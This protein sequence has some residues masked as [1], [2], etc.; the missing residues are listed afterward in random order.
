MSRFFDWWR[1]RPLLWL[2]VGMGLLVQSGALLLMYGSQTRGINAAMEDLAHAHA[3]QVAPLFAST[4]SAAMAQRD[5]ATVEAIARESQT[6]DGIEFIAV[7]D[8]AG[9]AVSTHAVAHSGAASLLNVSVPLSLSGQAL[10]RAELRFSRAAIERVY[11]ALLWRQILTIVLIL[12]VVVCGFGVLSY[13]LIRPLQRLTLASQAL[14]SGAAPAD[15]GNADR[16][17][18]DPGRA[19]GAEI[20]VLQSAFASMAQAIHNQLTALDTARHTAEQASRAKSEFLAKI[21]HEIRTP[22]NGM[23]GT[24][25][26]LRDTSLTAGQRELADIAQESGAALLVIVN[27]ILDF[28]RIDAG[29]LQ[30]EQR[31]F[32]LRESLTAVTDL[33]HGSAT[34]KGLSL[35]VDVAAD[36]PSHILGDE[37]RLRQVL[38]NLISNAIKYSERGYI[39]IAAHSEAGG[40]NL[41]LS[42]TDTGVGMDTAT[43]PFI[44]DPFIQGDNSATRRHGGT[45]LGLAIVKSL[46]TAM[47]G[48]ID[49]ESVPGAGS[50]F[51]VRLPLEV[52]ENT[53]PVTRVLPA[54]AGATG[55]LRGLHVLAVE[56]NAINRLLVETMLKKFGCTYALANN[57]QEALTLCEAAS[58]DLI[59]MDCHM[60][61]MDGFEATQN[62][63]EREQRAGQAPVPII[64]LTANAGKNNRDYCLACGMDDF[65]AK[66][67]NQAQ[68]AAVMARYAD[69]RAAP[70]APGASGAGAGAAYS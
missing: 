46:V 14:A 37:L 5:Y 23:M 45:G 61:V 10:G 19:I 6:A 62:I 64:A 43:L 39:G 2:L 17:N 18:T 57:G 55:R 63:R 34:R 52:I 27:D 3:A 70:A 69:L 66:P 13:W 41:L 48:T 54:A 21:S 15:G 44:F 49:V 31:P 59:L 9:K 68:L 30:V 22:M 67:Y 1:S 26:L 65:L 20:G 8:A 4:L 25:D 42:V 11:A 58:F 16:G 53:V 60:P 36:L 28:S 35:V 24:V 56:D 38:A 50:K 51:T 32:P 12:A 29:Q 7:F 47:G 33:H 40:R